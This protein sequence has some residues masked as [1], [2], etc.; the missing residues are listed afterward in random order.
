M[1]KKTYDI[2][3]FPKMY[4]RGLKYHH[5]GDHVRAVAE[6][7]PL[8]EFK[9]K[10]ADPY[11]LCALSFN[12]L[13]N[14]EEGMRVV[15][16]ARSVIPYDF[17]LELMKVDSLISL[18][19]FDEAIALVNDA[20]EKNPDNIDVLNFQV[21][22]YQRTNRV[23]DGLD[24]ARAL[25]E[26]DPGNAR[27]LNS[28]G[29][30]HMAMQDYYEA[31]KIFIKA[32]EINPQYYPTLMNLA[33][34]FDN[35]KN[36]A[37][38]VQFFDHAL[39]VVP[40]SGLAICGKALILS[41]HGMVQE[42]LPEFE[43]GL[44]FLQTQAHNVDNYKLH[45][46]NY[47]FYIHYVPGVPR[48]KILDQIHKWRDQV[49]AYI[50]EKPRTSFENAPDPDRKLRLGMIS[51]SFARHPVT[52]MTLAAMKN[53]DKDKFELVLFP[54]IAEAKRD[55]VT[56]RYFSYADKVVDLRGIPQSEALEV[57]RAE[58]IDIMLELTGHSEGGGRLP[59]AAARMAPV[60]VKWVGGLFDT[61]GLPQMDWILG[62]AIEIPD[63]HE[64]WY[65]ER[66]YRMPDDYIVY[67][68]PGYVG[69]V[70]PLPAVKNGYVTFGNMNNLTKTNSFTIELWSRILHAVPGS[71]LLMKVSRLDDVYARKNLEDHFAR[72]GIG[73][74]RLIMEAGDKH[75]AFM[76]TYNRVDIALDPHPYSGGLTTC[77][78][79]W[80]GVPVITLP[81]ETF[82][83]R[84]AATHLHNA[85]YPDWVVDSGD[86]YVALA[87][88]W[89]NDLEGLSRLRESMREKVRVSPLCDGPLFA[90]N[91]E[92]A[93]RHMWADWCDEKTKQK[94]TGSATM[95]T[96]PKPKKKKKK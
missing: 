55:D 61:T 67:E 59:L 78:A 18:G 30:A 51:N 37:M 83:G 53:L 11:K 47:V 34:C 44:D 65:D 96:P 39:K 28:L 3:D 66:V 26:K 45:F 31:A 5:A 73:I 57:I 68:P 50:K 64:K 33:T 1:A 84:H 94:A 93:M 2:K 29:M 87:V 21:L 36:Y 74:D 46:S 42:M 20:A 23:K 95:V 17:E 24:S 91:F 27:H 38:A 15:D 48:Q 7:L 16:I 71:R 40:H 35:T 54:D 82:A 81:G 9:P 8:V 56:H 12:S 49:C 58:N 63:G 80:M 86:D 22:T 89:A 13:K 60:Q 70:K 25:V 43:R 88:K 76:E 4:E 77:E 69:E 79:L 10:V 92:R 85:G 52:W 14:F 72:Y 75:K 32:A 6:L 90:R 62:D 41:N 19:R